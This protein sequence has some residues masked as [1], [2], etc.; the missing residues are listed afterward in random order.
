MIV[1][2]WRFKKG[3]NGRLEGVNG[4]GD[5]AEQPIDDLKIPEFLRRPTAD[6][7]QDAFEERAA[8]REFDGGE[9]REEA[10]AGVK[11]LLSSPDFSSAMSPEKRQ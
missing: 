9:T 5:G 1:A 3:G 11:D 6:E 4:Q 10:E 2:L 7:L 8:I